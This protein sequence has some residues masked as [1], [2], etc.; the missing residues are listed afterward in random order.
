MQCRMC[1]NRWDDET[2]V[3]CPVCM[4][5]VGSGD[6]GRVEST[7]EFT[8]PNFDN[9]ARATTMA[10]TEEF[11]RPRFAP[12]GGDVPAPSEDAAEHGDAPAES[13][14]ANMAPREVL[15]ATSG[16]VR[17][18]MQPRTQ[19]QQTQTLQLGQ[20]EAAPSEFEG[21]QRTTAEFAPLLDREVAELASGDHSLL[22]PDS[23]APDTLYSADDTDLDAAHSAGIQFD[24]DT[25]I[26][27]DTTDEDAAE[28][29]GFVPDEVAPASSALQERPGPRITTSPPAGPAPEGTAE[30]VKSRKPRAKTT[31]GLAAMGAGA[32]S[33]KRWPLTVN[34]GA[35]RPP[36]GP[37]RRPGSQRGNTTV[38]KPEDLQPKRH[39]T[40]EMPALKVEDETAGAETSSS[41]ESLTATDEAVARASEAAA[42]A[43][44]AAAQAQALHSAP[45][46]DEAEDAPAVEESSAATEAMASDASQPEEASDS[47]RTAAVE[48][49]PAAD[50]EPDEKAAAAPTAQPAIRTEP[51][52]KPAV[53]ATPSSKQ[54]DTGGGRA[55][56]AIAAILLAVVGAV[57]LALSGDDVKRGAV[58]GAPTGKKTPRAAAK[59]AVPPSTGAKASGDKGEASRLPMVGKMARPVDAASGPVTP[60][61]SRPLTTDGG[62]AA[63]TVD[64]GPDAAATTA[65]GYPTL[66]KGERVP[67]EGSDPTAAAELSKAEKA[68]AERREAQRRTRVKAEQ[69][70]AA[71]I[72]AR[73][74]AT[75]DKLAEQKRVAAEKRA[76]VAAK[77]EAKK[78]ALA[79]KQAEAKRKSEERRAAV[80]AAMEAKKKEREAKEAERKAE[81]EKLAAALKAKGDEKK[82]LLAAIKAEKTAKK[83]AAAQAKKAKAEARKKALAEQKAAEAEAKKKR[84][85]EVKAKLE[86]R[87]AAAAEKKRLAA[88]AA[89]KRVEEAKARAAAK[90]AAAAEKKRLAAE[91]KQRAVA[92]RKAK[93]EADRKAK[94]A[95]EAAKMA[96]QKARMDKVAAKRQAEKERQIAEAKARAEAKKAKATAASSSAAD[97]KASAEKKKAERAAK[98]K[99]LRQA[100]KKAAEEKLAAAKAAADK[101]KAERLA[102]RAAKKKAAAEKA[103]AAQAAADK[104][105]ADR[106]AAR[107]AAKKAAAEKV[108]ARK[109][110]A[111]K[112]KAQRL[113][114]RQAAKKAAA[115]K[116]AAATAA[117]DKKRAERLAA[118]DAKKKAAGEAK[119]AATAKKAELAAQKKDAK[120]AA[121]APTTTSPTKPQPT[122][123]AAGTGG[124][125]LQYLDPR[126]GGLTLLKNALEKEAD[127]DA[128]LKWLDGKTSVPGGPVEVEYRRCSEPAMRLRGGKLRLCYELVQFLEKRFGY[129]LD[130]PNAARERSRD[131]MAY[132][133]MVLLTQEVT[134]RASMRFSKAQIRKAA[135]WLSI[136]MDPEHNKR[137]N[138]GVVALI[139]MAFENPSAVSDKQFWKSYGLHAVRLKQHLCWSYGHTPDAELV[140][141]FKLSDE[142]AK[143]C[144]R[145]WTALNKEFGP[146]FEKF[147]R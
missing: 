99:A 92:E 146:T 122:T 56:W 98:V 80:R 39:S 118:R 87:K 94:E 124:M 120:A 85:A 117:A 24:P 73:R 52:P 16:K 104:K 113:A 57:W 69:E 143:T 32:A 66:L 34:S 6:V 29:A 105:R 7:A 135:A 12:V 70:R 40:D 139:Q 88:E 115:E 112:K 33:N 58:A 21:E 30:R 110:E 18:V 62:P 41:L 38:M 75:Q 142:Q 42:A 5:P 101:K 37:M 51:A 136:S 71:R 31:M 126:G 28:S 3:A 76:A 141:R 132:M 46:E 2:V 93:R 79:D 83:E 1:N 86:A 123:V 134:K 140:G 128:L 60:D 20:P 77:M 9:L 91:A 114:A 49:E 102:A 121:G 84:A 45:A 107:E 23:T 63:A 54:P 17:S 145:E 13:P 116:K 96:A 53:Q 14:Y 43:I 82:R 19:R 125:R 22:D 36:L 131:A 95:K 130:D 90:K 26:E 103:A 144:K 108:A 25:G 64:G 109:A 11:V 129:F 15:R 100:R 8:A 27:L 4:T 68:E 133:L 147:V 72:E 48:P 47:A 10:K 81:R 67:I 44:A 50:A 59:K 127:M 89:R 119:A 78:K 106:L 111:A 138:R 74:K 55:V 35:Y 97:A 61:S 137:I 65:K